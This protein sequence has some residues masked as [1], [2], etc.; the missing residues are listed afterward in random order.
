MAADS[1]SGKQQLHRLV[2]NLAPEQVQAALR[3]LNYLAADPVLLSLL[4]A[5]PDDEPYTEEQ[6]R[7][8]AEAEAGIAGGEVQS[9]PPGPLGGEVCGTRN[10]M[11]RY[12]TIS[13]D[14][15][16]ILGDGDGGRFLSASGRQLEAVESEVVEWVEAHAEHPRRQE[17]EQ[18]LLHAA[19]RIVKIQITRGM[20]AKRI[21]IADTQKDLRR[22]IKKL[23]WARFGREWSYQEINQMTNELAME[24]APKF[25][26]FESEAT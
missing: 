1:S 12:L 22:E 20:E 15:Q 6:R 5:P 9:C 17:A 19:D 7:Q 8:D 26:G 4:N 10:Q 21:V 3:Y 2:E 13:D 24:L 11:P 16:L 14:L 25:S 18:W 23:L